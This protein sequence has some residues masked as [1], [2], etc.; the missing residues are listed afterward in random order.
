M[1]FGAGIALLS[2]V[3]E[4]FGEHRL[5]AGPVIG[6]TALSAVFL[7]AYGWHARRAAAPMLR[8]ALLR[9]RTFRVAVLGGFVTR[10]GLGGMPF[11]LPLLYQIGMGFPAWQAGLFTT[12]QA[13]AAMGMKVIGRQLLS[14]FGHRCVL[15]ANTVLLGLAICSFSL[16]G[17]QTPF[18]CILPLSFALGFISSL[19]FTSMNTLVYADVDDREA[20][21]AGSIASTAQQ[22]S[23]SFGV[24]FGALLAAW[25]LGAVDQSVAAQT[26]P[27]LHKAFLTMG[28][29][30]VLS[31]LTFWDAALERR[32]QREQ[33]R[34]AR[35]RGAPMFAWRDDLQLCHPGIRL[36][37]RI[38]RLQG[39]AIDRH[40]IEHDRVDG[41]GGTCRDQRDIGICGTE[42]LDV[43][44][45]DIADR[46]AR[47]VA[48]QGRGHPRRDGVDR[49]CRFLIR[50]SY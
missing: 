39:V 36:D 1:L 45:G 12:P 41:S 50:S 20:S 30:T 49:W 33:P 6:L 29:L 14:R 13:I 25:Y 9:V 2:Y 27:A 16:I 40:V 23:L 26:I 35:R 17:R 37:A 11:L 18:W 3:L 32:K 8:L 43:L 5:S 42:D 48:W 34:G 28:A 4:I 10:L 22:M 24:A 7:A 44:E 15:I 19:Q 38:A 21:Q 31:S 47:G 46:A